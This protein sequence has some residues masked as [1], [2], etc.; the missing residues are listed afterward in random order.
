[1]QY[2]YDNPNEPIIKNVQSTASAS[3]SE[4]SNN[5]MGYMKIYEKDKADTDCVSYGNQIVWDYLLIILILLLV[6][7]ILC[8]LS[9][10]V[11]W[12]TV[13]S[14]ITDYYNNMIKFFADKTEY[15]KELIDQGT[16]GLQKVQEVSEGF[17]KN[18]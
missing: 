6:I 15:A 13:L 2:T 9:C 5:K 3:T 14:D 12:N 1:M 17:M 11:A 7:I 8:Q 18:L 10:L 16:Q 4:Y